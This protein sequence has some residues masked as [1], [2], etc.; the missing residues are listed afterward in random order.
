MVNNVEK[1]T[2]T[3][4]PTISVVIPAYNAA[5]FVGSAIES[6]LAQTSTPLEVLVIDDGSRDDTAAVVQQY[7]APVGLLRQSNGGPASARNHGVRVARG[8]WIA[9]LDADDT[10]L[11]QKL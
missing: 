7:A 1:R 10:W 2:A 6:A 5:R 8:E 11:P 4:A 3:T 9:F